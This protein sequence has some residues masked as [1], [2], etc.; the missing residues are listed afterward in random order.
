MIFIMKNMVIFSRHNKKLS[1][2]HKVILKSI[3]LVFH[4]T[5]VGTNNLNILSIHLRTK[6]Q[7]DILIEL[8]HFEN[9]C[10]HNL[11]AIW[12]EEESVIRLINFIWNIQKSIKHEESNVGLIQFLLEA[13]LWQT[14]W[15]VFFSLILNSVRIIHRILI[16]LYF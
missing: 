13:I 2:N 12:T 7:D 16:A 8:C 6:P 3:F 14:H 1:S 4:N 5:R 9:A 15:C 11:D 10:S